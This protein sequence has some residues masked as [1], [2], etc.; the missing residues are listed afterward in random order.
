M[1]RSMLQAALCLILSP[2]LIAQQVSP[3]MA[4]QAAISPLPS[5]Y[6]ATDFSSQTVT[7][8]MD[9]R[10]A[11]RF[12]PGIS[13]AD[14]K[15]G[16]RIRYTLA[17]DLIAEGHVVAPAGTAVYSTISFAR[18]KDAT[19]NAEFRYTAPELDLGNGNRILFKTQDPEPSLNPF[20]IVALYVFVFTCLMPFAI[21]KSLPHVFDRPPKK[22]PKAPQ[23]KPQTQQTQEVPEGEYYVWVDRKVSFRLDTLSI[24]RLTEAPNGA[25]AP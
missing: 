19:Q 17:Y 9:T 22:Q 3:A 13:S 18:R 23:S 2:L 4:E 6:P 12:K 11:L 1:I 21:V 24:P 15:V 8:P 25:I 20:R 5:P 16:D 7:I 10:V 14:A